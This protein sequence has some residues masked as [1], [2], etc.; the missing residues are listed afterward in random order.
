[1]P[2][3]AG[4]GRS[5]PDRGCLVIAVSMPPAAPAAPAVRLTPTERARVRQ[6]L[7][8][9]LG[10]GAPVS[11]AQVLAELRAGGAGP[12][13]DVRVSPSVTPDAAPDEVV[14]F[15]AAAA[16]LG[17]SVATAKRYAAPSSGKL[18][19]LGDGVSRAGLEALAATR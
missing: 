15:A 6:R 14:T 1:M 19:R 12:A 5:G 11:R 13:G 10:E 2:C 8:Q 18:V 7:A 9:R 4:H 17:V 16:R 3:V